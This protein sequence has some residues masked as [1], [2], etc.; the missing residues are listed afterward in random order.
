MVWPQ[1]TESSFSDLLEKLQAGDDRAVSILWERYFIRMLLVARRKLRG[2]KGKA[3]D[4]EDI[5]LS[6]FK[7]FCVGL[8]K[9]R[10]AC[11]GKD[12]ELWPLLVTLTINKAINHLRHENRKK[13]TPSNAT[14]VSVED[15]LSSDFVPE[16]Q[17]IADESFEKLLAA[18][19]ATGDLSLQTVALLRIEDQPISEIAVKLG[20]TVRTVQRKL[21]TIRAIWE[22][23]EV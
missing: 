15:L 11:S 1:V 5:A 14:L 6:A 21:S 10:F 17:L 4:E 20:C 19:D 22:A 16:V 8:Q 13:R 7:S 12:R 2:A 23:M 18:L 3:R 9:G